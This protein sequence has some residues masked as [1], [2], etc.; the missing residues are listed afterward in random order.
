M[1]ILWITNTIF[2]APC[3]ALGIPPPV[4]GGW[5]YGDA[6]RIANQT[7]IK[8]AVASTFR[9]KR[10]KKMAIQGVD[11]YL[12]PFIKS[13]SYQK[14]LE[15]HWKTICEEFKP[16]IIHIHGTEYAHGLACMRSC[17][18]FKYIVSIQ[19]LVSV[20]SKYY[21][22]GIGIWDIIK[23][24]TFRDLVR[25]DTIFQAKLNFEKRGQFEEEYIQKANIV[26][27]RTSWDYAH[28]KTINPS[29]NYHFNNSALRNS[30]YTAVKWDITTKNNYTI[31]LSQAGYPI[32]GLHQ[33]LKA[34]AILKKDFHK[35]Q[36]RIAGQCIIQNNSLLEKIKLSG[37]GSYIINL[38]KKFNLKE[39]IC[40][41]GLLD[42]K[43]MITEY[44]NAH[45]FI[46]P[47]SIENSP[48]SVGEAQILGIPTIGSYVGG[49]P[50]M[51]EHNINGLL[52]RFEEVEMLAEN[53]RSVFNNNEFANRLSK[54]GI[55]TAENRH[56]KDLNISHILQIYETLNNSK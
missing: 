28:V 36:L 52:Y 29:I 19:G 40:F 12:L 14:N 24:I 26:S 5:M 8:L 55:K 9:E 31:F 27:G 49:T 16:D 25:F 46:C 56:N 44:R 39:N 1:N 18:K 38:I 20:I 21:F 54:N 22:S 2:P 51:I 45:I 13:S 50:D 33:V 37:Y 4:F 42:E 11:Y 47:S 6:L 32:K 48:N 7:D 17:P 53:I 34:M 30:F 35:I 23:N 41:T 15:K 3:K 10:V 43:E